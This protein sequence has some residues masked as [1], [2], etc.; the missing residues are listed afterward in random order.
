MIGGFIIKRKFTVLSV[1]GSSCALNC[2]YCSTKY[3]S[4]MESAL[5]PDE[6]Y[7]KIRELYNNGVKG[8]LISGGFDE[9]GEL[10]IR[11]Y[12]GIMKKVKK[13]MDVVFNIHPGI[14]DKEII[15]ELKDVVDMVDY[16]FPYSI[17]AF[18]SKGV[19][20]EREDYI[21]TLENLMDF[22]PKY[23]VPHIMLGIPSDTDEEI[24]NSIKILSSYKPYL[25]NFL[26]LIPTPNTPSRILK[27]MSVEKALRFIE[28]GSKLMNGHVS[29]GCMRPYQIKEQ[30]DREVIKRGLVERIA[31]PHH[32]VI[33]EFNLKLFDACCSLPEKYLEDFK[34]ETNN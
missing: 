18:R 9:K 14:L 22:G 4:S 13:E 3:I 28:L 12:I 26:I 20:R 10:P 33:N 27:P 19:K 1:T 6:M 15:E 8:F 11:N 16:E 21:K 23:I 2:F 34:Y 32:K 29:V 7:K 30:L 31:N 25:I 5:T 24:E 17:G